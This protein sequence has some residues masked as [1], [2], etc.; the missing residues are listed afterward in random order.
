MDAKTKTR[1]KKILLEERERVLN[2]A[3]K[4][5]D[6]IKIS[7][8]DLSDETDHAV[9]E[10]SQNL[11][12]T[13]RDRERTLLLS[14]NSALERIDNG[15]FG[16]CESCEDPIELKRLEVRPMCRLCF[17]CQEESEHK[18]KLFA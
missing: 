4:P 3:S 5:L 8:D 9:S 17:T 1:F 10:L 14:I 16:D 2:A 6:D 12:L 13:L 18:R 15:S 11:S 7:T